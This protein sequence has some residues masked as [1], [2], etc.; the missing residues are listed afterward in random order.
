MEF[1]Y[2]TRELLRQIL[3]FSAKKKAKLYL[4]GGLLRDILLKRKRENP[5]IDLC[6]RKSAIS[7]G[8]A[9]AKELK[10]GFVVL[11]KEHGACRIVKR[12]EGKVYTIDI[13]DFRGS[14]LEEDLLHRDFTI[15]TLALGLDEACGDKPLSGIIDLYAGR[16]DLKNKVLK[17]AH[18]KSFDEDPLRILR[19]FAFACTL[20]FK[21]EKETLRLIKLKKDKLKKVSF[22]R[23]RDEL[24][25]IFDSPDS[26]E[27]IEAMDKLKI[28]KVIFPEFE[29]MRGVD[30]GPYH[31]LDI[32]RHS[33]ETLRQL[34]TAIRERKGN[35]EIRN[36][37]DEIVSSERKRRALMKLGALLH[38][39]GKPEALR[40]KEGK[41]TFYGHER[42]GREFAEGISRRLKLSND[43]E[44][45]LKR[46]VFWH[47]RPG[48]LSDNEE[49]TERAKFRY[50]RDTGR[51][52]VSVLLVSLAD[53][54]ATRGPLTTKLS[55][56]RHEKTVSR[57]IKEYFRK[58]KEK[59]QARIINGDDLIREFK[60]QPS[61]LIGK[62]LKDIEEL[63]AIG[64]VRTKEEAF[65]RARKIIN[66]RRKK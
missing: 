37:L 3:K 19:A 42:I 34:E 24:F 62:I 63:Q 17:I 47:L 44:D 11:D 27:Y 16:K 1:S 52:A 59:K 13:T 31:H 15:N 40:H 41:T 38:D 33:L 5:D 4:V 49:L 60:L 26:Y 30:Q 48:Y 28:L 29:L 54:R 53:Q 21:I 50:F 2:P 12:I 8:R 46:M 23:I 65:I 58:K 22:E 43:E 39:I 14:T 6:I 66:S 20:R 64:K 56:M 45:A 61:P 36:Y 10:S 18:K 25:K 7:F 35:P 55:R 57:L 9:L 51:E 32:W